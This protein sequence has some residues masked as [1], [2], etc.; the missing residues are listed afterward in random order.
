MKLIQDVYQPNIAI[1]S[2][3]GHFTMGPK[4]AA[5]AVKHLLDVKFVIPSHT[6]PSEETAQSAGALA[7]LLKAFPVV[8]YMI[9][10]DNE[11]EAL[12]KDYHQTK[13]ITLAHGE[14]RAF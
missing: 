14:E 13:V 2:S 10:R 9:D 12:L 8:D 4:E 7:A 6:F 1:L 5:Y 3:S 11:L